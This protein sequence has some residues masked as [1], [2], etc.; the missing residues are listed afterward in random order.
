MKNKNNFII[1]FLGGRNKGLSSNLLFI[2]VAVGAGIAYY[3]IKNFGGNK[4]NT[5]PETNPRSSVNDLRT[6]IKNSSKSLLGDYDDNHDP[7]KINVPEAGT[8]AW[9]KNRDRSIFPPIPDPN[10]RI[11]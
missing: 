10:I 2:S 8:L 3:F 1:P 4:V 6:D 5:K 7:I 11:N 9:K